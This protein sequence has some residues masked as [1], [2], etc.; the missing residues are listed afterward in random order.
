MDKEEKKI[1]EKEEK[2][3]NKKNNLIINL[4]DVALGK[5]TRTTIIIRNIPLKYKYKDLEKELEPFMGKYDCLLFPYNILYAF[6][7]LKTQ[8]HLLL[9]Y[10]Y[11]NLKFWSFYKS[12][13]VCELKYPNLQGID[14]IK[15]QANKYKE[16]ENLYFY[17]ETNNDKNNKIEIPYKYLNLLLQDNPKMKFVENKQDNTFIVESFK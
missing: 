16:P 2:C 4:E 3:I 11:F 6:L 13:I 15:K 10:E 14:E 8:Y 9:F 12:M 7:N 5:E 17:L 1:I